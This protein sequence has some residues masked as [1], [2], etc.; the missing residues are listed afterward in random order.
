MDSATTNTAIT[1]TNDQSNQGK[2]V[3]GFKGKRHDLATKNRISQTQ[4]ARY[5]YMRQM[6]RQ[7]Q[8]EQAQPF[9]PIDIDSPSFTE[10]I[11]EIL[12]E[13]LR[14]EIKKATPIRREIPLF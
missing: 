6:M 1:T 10:R 12:R 2:R 5:N 9:G 14:E 7:Q 3:G 11:R 4:K 13:L 8:T